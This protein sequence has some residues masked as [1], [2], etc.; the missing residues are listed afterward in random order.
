MSE[1]VQSPPWDKK[2]PILARGGALEILVEAVFSFGLLIGK[3]FFCQTRPILPPENFRSGKNIGLDPL[4]VAAISPPMTGNSFSALDDGD[5]PPPLVE[6]VPPFP[7][8]PPSPVP[9]GWDAFA[10]TRADDP[11][12][13][14]VDV[15]SKDFA[16]FTGHLLQDYHRASNH[17]ATKITRLE[18]EWQHDRDTIVSTK[19][20][21][22]ATGTSC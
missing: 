1:E 20:T 12:L 14:I 3:P 10:A 13:A 21:K 11:N 16:D 19:T 5:N 15:M 4:P 2:C 7:P 18:Q 22:Q 17:V 8:F 9:A 6:G